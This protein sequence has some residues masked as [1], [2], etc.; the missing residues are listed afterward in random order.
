M[1]NVE[2]SRKEEHGGLSAA[3]TEFASSL[4]RR[5]EAIH[6][7]IA[8]L[9]QHAISPLHRDN[10]LRRLHALGAS[11]KILG[12][13]AAA[14]SLS[15]AEQQLRT[16]LAETLADDLAVVR[17]LLANL[18]TLVLRGTYSLLPG[19][20]STQPGFASSPSPVA[21][22][23]WCV[24]VCGSPTLADSLNSVGA[25]SSGFELVQT[26]DP[27]RLRE[28]C[29]M[30]GP[31]V[32][33]LD[34][35]LDDVASNLQSLREAPETAGVHLVVAQSE[36]E[37]V[38]TLKQAGA[39]TVLTSALS[40]VALWR[41]ANRTRVEDHSLPSVREPIGDV[42]LRDLCERL[43]REV[44]RGLLEAADEQSQSAVVTFGEGTEIRA[45]IWAAVAR[46]RE[47]IVTQS[48]GRIH[49]G[50]GPDGSV[51]LAPGAGLGLRGRTLA[52]SAS[53]DLTG[54][55]ILVA[56][57]DPAV[58]WF[59]GGT[60]RAA[61]A[62]VREAQDGRR[63]LGLVYQWGP[64]LVVSDVLMP[65]MDGF[66]LCREMKRDVA[67]R[68][69]P[70]ILLSWKEDLLFRLREL[71]A[72]A[73]AY[74]RK[75][76]SAS[77]LVDRVRE[78][79][80]PRV[81]LERRLRIGQEVRGRLDGITPHTLIEAACRL[82]RSLR[83][84][85]RDAS[86]HFDVRIR[87]HTLRAVARTRANGVVL[88]GQPALASLLGV[89]AGRFSVVEDDQP[90][91]DDFAESNLADVLRTPIL[92]ARAAQR[93]LSGSALGTVERVTLDPDT[94]VDE[95]S[96]LP[97]SLRP[98]VD[99]LL[100]GTAPSQ[101]LALGAASLQSLESLLSDAAR[102]GAVQT[103][104]GKDGEDLLTRE[105]LALSAP[106]SESPPKAAIADLP[107]FTF[108]LTPSPAPGADTVTSARGGPSTAAA[109][110]PLPAKTPGASANAKGQQDSLADNEFDWAT[111]AS[112]ESAPSLP[113]EAGACAERTSPYSRPR[114]SAEWGADKRRSSSSSKLGASNDPASGTSNETPDLSRVVAAVASEGAPQAIIGSP[115][116]PGQLDGAVTSVGVEP[117]LR[118][119]AAPVVR[120][121]PRVPD[122]PVV[123][124]RASNPQADVAPSPSLAISGAQ[125]IAP[126]EL[127][128]STANADKVD[129]S[130]VSLGDA[131]TKPDAE[132]EAVFPLY[133]STS[134]SGKTPRPAVSPTPVI[135]VGNSEPHD[136][137]HSQ[138]APNS[139][140]VPKAPIADGTS[141]AYESAITATRPK[142]F[143]PPAS[144]TAATMSGATSE[145][146]G[147][148]PRVTIESDG[149]A[150]TSPNRGPA[151][152]D[153][154]QDAVAS[155]K[156]PDSRHAAVARLPA[157]NAAGTRS[158]GWLVPA[159]LALTAGV[160]SFTV[161]LPI[162]QRLRSQPVNPSGAASSTMQIAAESES[163]TPSTSD[164]PSPGTVPS[165]AKVEASQQS[166]VSAET[167][168]PG[169]VIPPDKGLLTLKTGGV[170]SI[171]V[172]DEFVGRGPE[173]TVTLSP[174][175]HR[176]RTSLNGE[177]HTENVDVAAGRATQLALDSNGK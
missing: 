162:V 31:D 133:A 12:F 139:N 96:M 104:A 119:I 160:L 98:L 58:A 16:G 168:L 86:A 173:R 148:A 159:S 20:N 174:G 167:T 117:N 135:S 29:A 43:S 97:L 78:L 111:E 15:R 121:K 73:D 69:V 126:R 44:R 21:Q 39:D 68:D 123:E 147:E 27:S 90:L 18:P 64:E 176:V 67:V 89:S 26:Q 155:L 153:T 61:G 87:D 118:G 145:T 28:L 52:D 152:G 57:D 105:I 112:W 146:L 17:S 46:I 56:D 102:R 79:L 42:G 49:F 109:S 158:S 3:R 157:D 99:E 22:G 113:R 175:Q 95:L 122:A 19:P 92:R 101:L 23:P 30:Y 5:L 171:F 70:V 55:R 116:G 132:D 115:I 33:V 124:I 125:D 141:S 60:L 114:I 51:V 76:A 131:T 41:A 74:V 66:A 130:E 48:E 161:A 37:A 156:D 143:P 177:E 106:T 134:P 24:L 10:L 100:R 170:H 94:F 142:D 71:G 82:G 25:A 75:E 36:D 172:D 8:A 166:G 137:L 47:V 4:T 108:Q 93:V 2:T 45:A 154:H 6:S 59:V 164:S 83:I 38:A 144:E 80:W 14:E 88:R 11:A 40:P 128:P 62:E 77:S 34:G 120:E 7:A 140:D 151:T 149:D 13:A 54:R 129:E 110:A 81:S 163:G 107:L 127:D 150:A 32:V 136:T 63:A 65:G 85:L 84:T 165:P 103:I 138:L 91:D 9:E 72:D 53:I 35:T 169:V 1:A 50:P